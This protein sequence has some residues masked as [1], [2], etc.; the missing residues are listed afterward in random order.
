[1][2]ATRKPDELWLA[3]HD[4]CSPARPGDQARLR[5]KGRMKGV[6]E[7]SSVRL[8]AWLEDP[9]L[10]GH[11]SVL[12]RDHLLGVLFRRT[13]SRPLATSL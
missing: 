6:L 5:H 13:L 10:V 12:W 7:L 4:M 9:C 2:P 8:K 1:M 11:Y 3:D